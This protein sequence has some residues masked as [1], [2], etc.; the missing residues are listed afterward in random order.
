MTEVELRTYAQAK[1]P[2]AEQHRDRQLQSATEQCRRGLLF[3]QS[4][5]LLCL[6]DLIDVHMGNV[7][8]HWR[9][10][11]YAG[12]VRPG[13]WVQ[14]CT[15]RDIY[16]DIDLTIWRGWTER[17]PELRRLDVGGHSGAPG[18]HG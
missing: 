12:E 7:V 6:C 15:E 10:L 9:L 14:V 1:S 17:P 3:Q 2:A 16:L 13:V 18:A 5:R 11:W 4:R 8:V